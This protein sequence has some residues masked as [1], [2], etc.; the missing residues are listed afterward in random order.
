MVKRKDDSGGMAD[1]LS[2][3]ILRGLIRT[4]LALPYERR[5][6]LMG[7]IV[8]RGVGPLAGYRARAIRHLGQIYPDMSPAMRKR[9]ADNV[10][11]NAGRTLIENYAHREFGQRLAGTPV[12][13]NGLDA[14]AEAKAQ[15]RPVIFVTG[16]FGNYEAPRHVLHALGYQIGGIYRAMSN[17]FFNAHYVK[18]MQDVSGPVFEKG[19]RGT[20]G[21]A[22]HLKSG[23]MATILFDVRDK[24]G[25]AVNFLGKPA[26]TSTSAAELALKFDA[27]VI[28][29]FGTRRPDG[30]SFDIAIEDPIPHDDPVTMTQNMT[31]RLA[32]RVNADP[33]Q[34]F[35]IHDRWKPGRVRAGAATA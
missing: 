15:N 27:V 33:A 23:G 10:T 28:P 17:P 4:A 30:L 11:E 21:F 13:G 26:W 14:L 12:S 7:S 2:D 19:R 34:W 25:V 1:W 31:D 32:A 3:R 24:Q 9:I 18:T 20:M 29:Y 22:R 6:P 16:H 8:R 5:V 35:W